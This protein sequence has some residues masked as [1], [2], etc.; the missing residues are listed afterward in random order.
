MSTTPRSSGSPILDR[1]RSLASRPFVRDVG[2]LQVGALF[3]AGVGFVASV[4][5]ARA[6]GA[7]QYGTYALVVSIGTTVGLLRRLGQDYAA[8]TRLAAAIALDDVDSATK[9]M[10][11]FVSIGVWSATLI[12]PIAILVAPTATELL[13]GNAVLGEL[14]RLYLLPVSWVVISATTVLALQ[15]ARKIKELAWLENGS[16]ALLAAAAI[17]GALLGMTAGA[18]LVGQLVASILIALVSVIVY[19]WLR[20][21]SNLLPSIKG[22]LAGIVHPTFPVWHETRSG[23]AMALDKNLATIYPL[24]PVL[25]LGAVAATDDVAHLRIALSYIAIPALLLSPISRLLMVKLP[26]V[27]ARTPERLRAFFVSVSLSGVII[28]LGL[29]LPFAIGA[30]W[31]I[32]SLYG[33]AYADSVPLALVLA[34]D[35]ALLGFGL[36]AGPLFRTLDRTD[37]P[38]RVHLVVLVIGLPIAFALIRSAGAMAAAASYVALMLA[39]RLATNALCWRLLTRP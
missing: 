5:L 14:L 38:I 34:I 19:E 24:F 10:S 12:I 36:T 16:N 9:A 18:V 37:L 33:G 3:S 11:Y 21:R 32:T 29:T 22:L 6:L 13:Y 2:I 1:V 8:T 15:S 35:S 23:L 7:E 20:R 30:P 39:A 25:F 17:G 27:H 31:L 4:V 26:E 28:S